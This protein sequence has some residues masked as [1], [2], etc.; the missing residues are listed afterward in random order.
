MDN[1]QIGVRFPAM[2]RDLFL[3]QSIQT[4]PGTQPHI[5]RVPVA[6]CLGVRQSV[7]EADLSCP[8]TAKV[9]SELNYTDT[10]SNAIIACMRTLLLFID[11][12]TYKTHSR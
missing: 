10:P 4:D 5:Q 12:K 3:L 1:Q 11:R 6:L 8:S 2:A 9:R 7:H